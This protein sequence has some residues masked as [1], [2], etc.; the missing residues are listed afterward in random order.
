MKIYIR[1]FQATKEWFL[2]AIIFGL[3]FA[4]RQYWIHQQDLRTIN[5]FALQYQQAVNSFYKKTRCWP[6]N[7]KELISSFAQATSNENSCHKSLKVPIGSLLVSS[8]LELNHNKLSLYPCPT[9]QKYQLCYSW[10]GPE[11]QKWLKETHKILGSYNF[12]QVKKKVPY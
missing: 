9:N 1:F 10:S 3:L 4:G 2:I 11:A 6:L 8:S 12:Q 5:N 7:N